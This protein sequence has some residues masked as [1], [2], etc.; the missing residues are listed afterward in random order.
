MLAMQP[1]VVTNTAAA[2]YSS[3]S[4]YW[5]QMVQ[6]VLI[7]GAPATSIRNMLR[8]SG[9]KRYEMRYTASG[10]ASMPC[11]ISRSADRHGSATRISSAA[12][13]AMPSR[14]EYAAPRHEISHRQQ[15]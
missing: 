11:S 15:Y 7:T 3:S 5:R 14:P 6:E 10:A 12:M 2:A 13:D 4:A 8:Y 9:T 1:S